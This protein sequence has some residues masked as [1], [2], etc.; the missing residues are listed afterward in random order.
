MSSECLVMEMCSV[1][2]SLGWP[3]LVQ[4]EW[5]HFI[6]K[7]R[8]QYVFVIGFDRGLKMGHDAMQ[9]GERQ[10][11]HNGADTLIHTVCLGLEAA[12]GGLYGPVPKTI[13][14]FISQIR[15]S[16]CIKWSPNIMEKV[17][18]SYNLEVSLNVK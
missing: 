14:W 15:F 11:D 4:H 16:Q 18:L 12:L 2:I 7:S 13:Q 9:F 1:L 8:Y 17:K 10:Y 3:K 5:T 6:S